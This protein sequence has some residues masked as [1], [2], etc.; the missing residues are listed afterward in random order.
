MVTDEQFMKVPKYQEADTY[1]KQTL[2][3]QVTCYNLKNAKFM[4]CK[5]MSTNRSRQ[6]A[7]EMSVWELLGMADQLV[8]RSG[9]VFALAISVA[10][11]AV[12]LNLSLLYTC[13]QAAFSTTWSVGNSLS[14]VNSRPF[15]A[16][17]I[18]FLYLSHPKA[19]I[20]RENPKRLEQS[21]AF[22]SHSVHLVLSD[23]IE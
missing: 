6:T 11:L 3:L 9:E 17:F 20:G 4:G 5:T 12:S 8:C 18:F 2:N 14:S 10:F 16:R 19:V 13:W 1:I 23:A 7:G 21:Q 15:A 22:L